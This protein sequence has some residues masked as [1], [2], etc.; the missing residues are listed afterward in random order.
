MAGMV[1]CLISTIT[2]CCMHAHR[3]LARSLPRAARRSGPTSPRLPSSSSCELGRAQERRPT[4]PTSLTRCVR[5]L[6]R[7]ALPFAIPPSRR[8]LRAALCASEFLHCSLPLA[9][10]HPVPARMLHA[11]LRHMLPSAN[12]SFI[13]AG[14][15]DM[16]SSATGFLSSF[17][18]QLFFDANQV[19]IDLYANGR[20]GQWHTKSSTCFPTVCFFLGLSNCS[21]RLRAAPHDRHVDARGCL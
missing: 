14:F 16:N 3:R 21:L 20:M 5:S 10:T 4:L 11:A 17:G 13:M 7:S 19:G 15:R 18:P 6:R 12:V 2:L 1:S 9:R 8:S